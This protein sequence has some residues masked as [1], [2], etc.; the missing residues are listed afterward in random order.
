MTRPR[1]VDG[2]QRALDELARKLG[3][4]VVPMTG[5]TEIGFDRLYIRDH[6]YICEIK[7]GSLP[8]SKRELT[9]GEKRRRAQ[10]LEAGGTYHVIESEMD[11]MRLFGLVA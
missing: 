2:N 3:A 11:L 10:I 6:I 9:D 1:R 7:D 5:A 8:P 4:A